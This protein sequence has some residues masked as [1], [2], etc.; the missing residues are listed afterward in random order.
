MWCS[1]ISVDILGTCDLGSIGVADNELCWRR[2]FGK[3]AGRRGRGVLLL[4]VL[5]CGAFLF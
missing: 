2:V 1:W 5:E 3:L 4:M